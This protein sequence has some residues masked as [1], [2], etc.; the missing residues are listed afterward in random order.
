MD[1]V[2]VALYDGVDAADALRQFWVNWSRSQRGGTLAVDDTY[3]DEYAR[4]TMDGECTL[5]A[6]LVPGETEPAEEDA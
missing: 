4:A 5:E 2:G 1:G 6:V 3:T